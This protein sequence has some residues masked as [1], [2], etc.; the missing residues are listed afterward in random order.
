M[1]EIRDVVKTIEHN[2]HE[3]RE[4]ISKAYHLME[5]NRPY[6]DWQREMA[7]QHLAFNSKGHEIVKKMIA[8][9]ADNTHPL[10]PGMRAMYDDM[11]AEIIR[12]TAEV[13]AMIDS[14]GK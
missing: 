9:Q 7:A 12:E 5:S 8:D 11:H 13:R 10:A 2:V 3:A 6:A 4:K 1:R 14:Y